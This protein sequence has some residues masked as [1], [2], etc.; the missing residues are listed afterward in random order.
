MP[1]E[2]WGFLLGCISLLATSW[3]ARYFFFWQGK[4][5]SAGHLLGVALIVVTAVFALLMIVSKSI[6]VALFFSSL[7]GVI[8]VIYFM[9]QR[10]TFPEQIAKSERRKTVFFAVFGFIMFFG[11]YWIGG[12][13]E[14]LTAT[15]LY[16]F[17]AILYILLRSKSSNLQ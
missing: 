15:G 14:A 11:L 6:G 3:L 5:T 1:I 10:K 4:A 2:L 8:V 16:V 13:N 17:L 7:N 9:L 12:L